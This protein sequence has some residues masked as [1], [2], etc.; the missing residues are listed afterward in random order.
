MTWKDLTPNCIEFGTF[1]TSQ[2]I[3]QGKDTGR[4]EN[5]FVTGPFVVIKGLKVNM[6]GEKHEP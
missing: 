3:F 2:T 6:S 5:G 1:E 4:I